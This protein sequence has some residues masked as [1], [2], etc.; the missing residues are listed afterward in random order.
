M[1]FMQFVMLGCLQRI[2]KER[3]IYSIYH[4][5]TGKK[6]SQTIQDAHLYHLTQW[7]KVFP[8]IRRTDYERSIAELAERGFILYDEPAQKADLTDKGT[9]ALYCAGRMLPKPLCFNGWLYQDA[10]EMLWK[11]ISLLVQTISHLIRKEKRYFP[12][13]RD[14]ELFIWIKNFLQHW[15]QG[16]DTLGNHL[17][18]E[19]H[20]IFGDRFPEEP[21][22]FVF[23]LSGFGYIGMTEKQAADHFGMEQSEYSFRFMN[24]L[25]FMVHTVMNNSAD[26]PILSAM[27]KDA[28]EPVP[29]TQSTLQTYKLLRQNKTIEQIAASRKLKKSTIE[30]HIIEIALVDKLFP[31]EAFVEKHTEAEIIR[32]VKK[33]GGRKLKPIKEQVDHVSY[34]QIRLVLAR[35]GEKV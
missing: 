18:K 12:V 19:F 32:A 31:I 22:L 15:P 3:T 16:R 17:H 34:F 10:A 13:Q 2:Q 9:K 21:S 26:F 7:F 29:F 4:L 5:L 11:R 23:R 33:L 14:P 24:C 27:V 28:Y 20:M 30:D 8:K 25:H 6:S 1:N 35:S